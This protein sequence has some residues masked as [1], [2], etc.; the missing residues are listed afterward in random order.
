[1]KAV[2]QSSIVDLT[3]IEWRIKRNNESSEAEFDCRIDLNRM[4]YLT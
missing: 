3:S 1:M 2:R 4:A